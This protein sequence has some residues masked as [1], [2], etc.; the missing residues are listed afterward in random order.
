MKKKTIFSEDICLSGM[1]IHVPVPRKQST[2]ELAY[3][4]F[5][6]FTPSEFAS[7]KTQPSAA[8]PRT[9]FMNSAARSEAV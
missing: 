5:S 4:F 6:T 9:T 7:T 2:S 8:V 1:Q 3:F